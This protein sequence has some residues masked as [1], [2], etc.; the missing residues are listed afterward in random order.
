[1]NQA[2]TELETIL[3]DDTLDELRQER[4]TLDA[5]LAELRKDYPEWEKDSPQ[6]EALEGQAA[7]LRRELDERVAAADTEREKA[8]AALS[9][10]NEQEKVLLARL[11]GV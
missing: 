9:E 11:S 4:A 10:A 5:T 8:Q 7:E 6:P 3:D 1:M 2:E